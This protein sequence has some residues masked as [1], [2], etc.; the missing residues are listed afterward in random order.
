MWGLVAQIKEL[1][2]ALQRI[3]NFGEPRCSNP[4]CHAMYL[5]A[6]ETLIAMEKR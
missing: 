5:T 2:T 1:R 6:M 4:E 3:V